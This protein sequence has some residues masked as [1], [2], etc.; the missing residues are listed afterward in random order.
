MKSRFSRSACTRRIAAALAGTLVLCTGCTGS[1]RVSLISLNNQAI[2]P[3]QVEPYELEAAECY[4]WVDDAG[5]LCIATRA[6][7]NNL[8][9][10]QFGTIELD[11]S[12]ALDKPPAGIGRD[13]PIRQRE[14]R[15]LIRSALQNHRFLPIA[16]I[17]SVLTKPGSAMHGSFRIWMNPIQE[18][19]VLSFLPPKTGP[20]LCYGTFRAVRNPKRGESIL[21]R[22]EEWG[23]PRPPKQVIQPAAPSTQTANGGHSP[24]Q[25]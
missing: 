21:K 20:I 25:P 22:S 1:A 3:P 14:A 8:F 2:D 18:V 11:F 13:Y 15:L 7:Q 4:W 10:G 12:L 16:G 9:L 6:E 19:G 17:V 24:A 23:F 5:D